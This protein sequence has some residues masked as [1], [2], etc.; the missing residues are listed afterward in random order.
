MKVKMD[1]YAPM[2]FGSPLHHRRA[3]NQNSL[4]WNSLVLGIEVPDEERSGSEP[5]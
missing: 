2:T 4:D 3:T 5:A 1:A